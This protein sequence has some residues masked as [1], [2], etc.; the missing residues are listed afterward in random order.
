MT[1]VY[2]NKPEVVG[3]ILV[4]DITSPSEIDSA[5]VEFMVRIV[6]YYEEIEFISARVDGLFDNNGVSLGFKDLQAGDFE[7]VGEFL[8]AVNLHFNIYKDAW[9]ERLKKNFEEKDG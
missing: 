6:N 3:D 9:L 4:F 8:K 2:G 7:A 1:E 5:A